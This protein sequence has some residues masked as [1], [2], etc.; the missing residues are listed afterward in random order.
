MASSAAGTLLL[1]I[2]AV[3]WRYFRDWVVVFLFKGMMC[4]VV[5]SIVVESNLLSYPVRLFPN[6]FDTSILF[7]V[8]VFPT[9][10]VIYNQITRKRGIG[11]IFYYALLFGGVITALEYPLEVYTALIHYKNW[12]WITSF[13][14][15]SSTFLISRLF[16]AFYRWGCGYFGRHSLY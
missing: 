9:L 6:A 13:L 8:W 3:D 14:A 16:I 15:L 7:E 10:C 1:L 4:L 5:G 2:F 12:S 11:P